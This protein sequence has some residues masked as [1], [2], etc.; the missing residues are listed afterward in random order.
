MKESKIAGYLAL[1]GTSQFLILMIVA[2][3]LYPGYSVK[4][5]YISD[6][7][8]GRTAVIFNVSVALLGVL[9][10]VASILMR[11]VFSYASYLVLL[12]GIGAL[13]VGL[14]PETTGLP[15]LI[16]ALSAFLFGGLAAILTSI[17]RNYFWTVL[18]AI[19]LISLF[20]YLGKMYGPLGN[21]GLERLIVYPEL[22]WGISLGTY[23]IEYK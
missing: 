16:G 11:K 7:G 2:E 4:N 20:L 13:I 19:T 9:V 3:A 1:V 5:N 12:N 23:L 18:G 15:H 21:G 8:V 14:F 22:V 6:L 10:I 17:K